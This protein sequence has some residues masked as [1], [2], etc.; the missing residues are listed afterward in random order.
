MKI[1]MFLP[2]LLLVCSVSADQTETAG[3]QS[4]PQDFHAELRELTTSLALQTERITVLQREQEKAVK[5]KRQKTEINQLKRQ[6]KELEAKL[7]S[8]KTEINQLKQLSEEQAGKLK[9]ELQ[10]QRTEANQ[11]K[12]QQHV[13]Q[14][15]F[16]ASLLEQGYGYTGPF[17]DHTTLVFKR[18]VTNIGNAYNK[19]T[20]IFTAP[21]RGV[22]HFDWKVTVRDST[23]TE[24]GDQVTV[25]VWAGSS[26]YDNDNHLT[27]FSGHLIFTM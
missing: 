1:I 17:Y 26:V 20:G 9:T 12:Q 19:N 10:N 8:Q 15:A 14:V 3:Q 25:R 18:V 24:V 22:Y 6:S 7:E 21:V 13:T 16:S 23:Q 4:C 27:T 2:L 5:L 11:M